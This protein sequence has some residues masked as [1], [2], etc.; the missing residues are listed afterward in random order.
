MD[1]LQASQCVQAMDKFVVFVVLMVLSNHMVLVANA[2][3]PHPR[4]LF[5]QSVAAA[6]AQTNSVQYVEQGHAKAGKPQ[7]L[8][9]QAAA[10]TD[11]AT[12][13]KL[14]FVDSIF[15]VGLH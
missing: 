11:P 1:Y 3:H 8:A 2:I 6:A 14:Q 12:N 10:P 5:L 4:F 9:Q 15:Q 13:F 7:V